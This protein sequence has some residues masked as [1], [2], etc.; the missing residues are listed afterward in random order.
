MWTEEDIKEALKDVYDPELGINIVDLG[1]VYG[2]DI[3][4]RDI[5]VRMT[6]TSPICPLGPEL[7]ESV[8]RVLSRLP[9]VGSVN[10]ELVWKP[11]WDPHKMA[12]EEA[13]MELGIY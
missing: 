11:R 2:V 10:V 12:S 3:K 5:T 9:M 1:L 4:D 7:V 6:L 8:K 13:K